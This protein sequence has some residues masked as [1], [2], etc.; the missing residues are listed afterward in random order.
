M[1]IEL[2]FFEDSFESSPQWVV[3]FQA[4][5]LPQFSNGDVLVLPGISFW[6]EANQQG[7]QFRVIK[8]LHVITDP[9]QR[10]DS[11]YTRKLLI[12]KFIP[13]KPTVDIYVDELESEIEVANQ[14]IKFLQHIAVSAGEVG[15]ENIIDGVVNGIISNMKSQSGHEIEEADNA[16]LEAAIILKSDGHFLAEL[17]IQNLQ[18][19][20]YTAI[21][22][23]SVAERIV[24]WL[25]YGS[26]DELMDEWEPGI[27]THTAPFDPI[28]WSG[29]LD[30][31]LEVT[32]SR[33]KRKMPELEEIEN[34]AMRNEEEEEADEK[35]EKSENSDK[36]VADQRVS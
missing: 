15:A 1:L 3:D 20:V 36:G 9:S 19:E 10:F 23:L 11:H 17:L 24:L 5:T 22:N 27:D 8:T 26:L 25:S 28:R 33:L 32:L 21:S 34:A 13:E 7:L 30:D 2:Q 31:A 6:E 29:N 12:E 14:K 16:W 35:S 4:H 18:D